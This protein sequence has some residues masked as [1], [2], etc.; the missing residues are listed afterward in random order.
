[1]IEAL[2]FVLSGFAAGVFSGSLGVGGA[3]LATPLIRLLGVS[4]YL[5]VGTTVPVL[6][7]TTGAGAYAYHR[8][9]MLDAKVATP[10]ALGGIVGA[11]AGAFT[12]RLFDGH[13]LMIFTAA[14]LLVMSLGLLPKEEE[15]ALASPPRINLGG[16]V[17]LGLGAGF[18]SGFLGIGG[19]FIMVPAFM[20]FFGVP[21]KTALGTSLAVITI[22]AIPNMIAHQIVGNIDWRI[23]LWLAIGVIPGAR[24]GARLSI[25][26]QERV[27]RLVVGIV[28]ALVA[29]AYAAVELAALFSGQ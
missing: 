26:A 15:Q 17:L 1:M 22:T 19:G 6:L 29:A 5:A 14:V 16:L 25:N 10:T 21:I 18:F 4:P 24:L 27:L 13:L 8:A 3:L 23:A 9:G 12:T 28:I 11:V 20:R 7:P 2:A